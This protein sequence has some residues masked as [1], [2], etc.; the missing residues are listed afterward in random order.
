MKQEEIRK[1][2]LAYE[3]NADSRLS[4]HLEEIIVEGFSTK[5]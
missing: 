5:P 2:F 1:L 4:R 3:E